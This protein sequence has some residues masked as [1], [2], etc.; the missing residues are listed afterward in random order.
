MK[1]EISKMSIYEIDEE[2][3]RISSLFKERDLTLE[4][5]IYVDALL[6]RLKIVEK[7]LRESRTPKAKYIL[8]AKCILASF[9]VSLIIYMLFYN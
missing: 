5:N 9:V 4:E 1:K 6:E 2:V 7:E 3:K 8:L